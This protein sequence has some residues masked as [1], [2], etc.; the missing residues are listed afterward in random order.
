MTT[1]WNGS[2]GNRPARK[3][4]FDDHPS[5]RDASR[6]P[7]APGYSGRRAVIG[8][9][10]T[11]AILTS[12][13]ALAFREWRAGYRERAAFGAG[14]VATAIEPLAGVVPPRVS[15]ADWHEAVTDARAMLVTL[16]AANLLDLDQMQALRD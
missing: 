8:G 11:L 3:I 13:L 12:C 5:G 4:R 1:V 15:P 16:T 2:P 9:V 14:H 6:P 10:L 7:E